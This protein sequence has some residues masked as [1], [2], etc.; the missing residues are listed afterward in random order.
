VPKELEMD[1][2][3]EILGPGWLE[4]AARQHGPRAKLIEIE[5]LGEASEADL[6][7]AASRASGALQ[8]IKEHHHHIARV[9]A[10]G[11]T[12][13]EA[14]AICGFSEERIST[15]QDDPMFSSLVEFY[16]SKGSEVFSD[17]YGQLLTVGKAAVQ[18]IGRRLVDAPETIKTKELVD[19]A[20][21]GFDRTG[22]GPQVKVQTE[23]TVSAEEI[24]RIRDEARGRNFVRAKTD[25]R[26]E[27]SGPVVDVA[28]SEVTPDGETE[29]GT[30]VREE[31]RSAA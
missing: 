31:S 17:V 23:A 10:M 1:G 19:V 7:G 16:R 25:H 6:K 15:L 26:T 22:Y 9:L 3:D 30:G 27:D 24:R 29:E 13:R 11:N 12:Q 28:F 2:L 8:E 5:V 21:L 4:S 20:K 18:E 14:A